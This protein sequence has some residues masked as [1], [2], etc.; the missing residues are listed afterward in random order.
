MMFNGSQF[1]GDIS[2]WDVS[3]VQNMAV[4]FSSSQFN[5]DLS[6]WDVSNVQ[7]M[8]VMFS[9]SQFNGDLSGWD[10][11]NVQKDDMYNM[12]DGSPLQNKPPKW[13]RG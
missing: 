12:F 6:G 7:N 10:V 5:G 2:G 13:Y 1:N 3:R 9:S 4:M 8:A 11:S